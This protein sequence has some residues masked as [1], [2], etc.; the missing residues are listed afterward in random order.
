MVSDH[1]P[2]QWATTKRK[3]QNWVTKLQDD[4]GIWHSQSSDLSQMMISH[5]KQILTLPDNYPPQIDDLRDADSICEKVSLQLTSAPERDL[6]AHYTAEEIEK[7]LFE[8][9]PWKAPGLDGVPAGFLGN[10]SEI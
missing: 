5:F 4:G 9:A 1:S 3:N 6:N 8:M 2:V 7:A 10:C